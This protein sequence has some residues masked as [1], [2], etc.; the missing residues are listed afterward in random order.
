MFGTVSGPVFLDQLACGGSETTVMQCRQN[1]P[2]LSECDATE[3][4]GVQCI[5]E[6]LIYSQ[7]IF[8]SSMTHNLIKLKISLQMRISVWSTMEGVLTPAQMSS[9]DTPAA[10]EM[11]MNWTLTIEDVSVSIPRCDR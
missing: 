3:I 1:E 7:G 2:G 9:L 6:W 4:V 11:D 5:G 8:G 10:V